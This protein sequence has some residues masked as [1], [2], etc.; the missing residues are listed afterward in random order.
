MTNSDLEKTAG[1]LV[2][3]GQGIFAADETVSTLTK[4][5][6][7]LRIQSTPASRRNYREML[8]TAPGAPEFV[9]GVILHDETIHQQTSAGGPLDTSM[10]IVVHLASY[11]SAS[12]STSAPASSSSLA[13]STAFAGVF[14][15]SPS[16]P[17]AAT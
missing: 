13:T 17:F 5:F 4:R 14:C 6:D 9:S 11:M 1:A 7:A 10:L 3:P 16:T 2:A 12:S 15:R 8:L